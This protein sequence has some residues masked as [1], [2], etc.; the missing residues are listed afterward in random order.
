MKFGLLLLLISLSNLSFADPSSINNEAFSVEPLIQSGDV[1]TP[2]DAMPNLSG[3]RVYFI[4]TQGQSPGLFQVPMTGGA[5]SPLHLGAPFVK[6]MGLALSSDGEWIFIAD[7]E[8]EGGVIFQFSLVDH[9]LSSLAGTEGT[10]PQGLEVVGE[11]LYVA[12]GD[13]GIYQIPLPDGIPY[14]IAQ[15]APFENLSSITADD[16]GV[17]FVTDRGLNQGQGKVYRFDKGIHAI[18]HDLY[19]GSPA[20]LALTPDGKILAG[21]FLICNGSCSSSLNRASNFR[22]KHF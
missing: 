17:I 15:G 3:D 4:A 18:A 5:A 2:L 22:A 9:S 16:T 8:A 19:L 13:Q 21:F 7:A 6:P 20:G 1:H 12:G 11:V 10:A 14:L